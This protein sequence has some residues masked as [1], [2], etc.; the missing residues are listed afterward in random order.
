MIIGS[1]QPVSLVCGFIISIFH[2]EAKPSFS[3]EAFREIET[4]LIDVVVTFP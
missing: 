3:Y 4:H 1:R 2:A